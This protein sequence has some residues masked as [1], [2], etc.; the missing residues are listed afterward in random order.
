MAIRHLP[1]GSGRDV[2]L[3]VVCGFQGAAADHEKLAFGWCSDG[4]WL[5]FSWGQPCLIVGNLNVEPSKIPCLR[6]GISAGSS[7]DLQEAWAC[8]S[9]VAPGATLNH[10]F[11]STGGEGG[12]GE[13]GGGGHS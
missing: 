2:H 8:A 1:A 13:R 4:C 5:V 12:G 9:G 11:A 10:S 3:V 6:Q 7:F